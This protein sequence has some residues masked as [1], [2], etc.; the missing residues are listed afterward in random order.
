MTLLKKCKCCSEDKELSLFSKAKTTKDKLQTYCKP[1][2][3]QKAKEFRLRN[4]GYDKKYY[5]VN[6]T[7][8][9]EHSK[10]YRTENKEILAIYNKQRYQANKEKIKLWAKDARDARPEVYRAKDAKRRASKLNATPKWGDVEK[11]KVLY[12]YSKLCSIVLKQT[13]HVDHIVPL[14]GKTVCGL[15]VPSNLQV[16]TAFE[17]ISKSN[18]IWP[19]M[20]ETSV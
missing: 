2:A 14:K 19:D 15:H 20:W 3:S 11:I 12:E 13:F 18:R 6:K 7:R 17:N 8:Y 1:C 10:S 4:E 16:L 9:A 5:A